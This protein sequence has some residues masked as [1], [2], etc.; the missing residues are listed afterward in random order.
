MTITI[1]PVSLGIGLYIGFLT[2]WSIKDSLNQKNYRKSLQNK[3]IESATNRFDS[4]KTFNR[5][6]FNTK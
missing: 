5:N 2:G 6:H 3:K 1:F 4:K